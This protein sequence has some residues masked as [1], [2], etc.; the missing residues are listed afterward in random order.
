M[1]ELEFLTEGNVEKGYGNKGVY[2]NDIFSVEKVNADLFTI[3][4][5]C[6]CY[7]SEDL[8]KEDL[9]KLIQELKEWVENK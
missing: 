5:E 4:E 6:D 1:N 7:H 8:S 3:R 9:L 2:F